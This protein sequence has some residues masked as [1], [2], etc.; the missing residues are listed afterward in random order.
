[1]KEMKVS[2][3]LKTMTVLAAGIVLISCQKDKKETELSLSSRA[4][5]FMADGGQQNVTVSTNES[6]TVSGGAAWVSVTP[7]SGSG[8]GS[9][10]VSAQANDTFD[11]RSAEL[12]VAAGD[13]TQTVKVS[14]LSQSPSID[15]QPTSL[16][17]GYEAGN[18]T[19]TITSNAP[20]TLTLSEGCDWITPDKTEGTGSATV[21]L[22][23][24]ANVLREAREAVVTIKETVGGTA[25]EVAVSQEMGPRSRLTDSLAL[26]EIYKAADGAHWKDGRVWDLD[27]AMDDADEKWY[28]VTLDAETGRVTALKLLKGTILSEWSLPAV[29]SELDELT[30]LRFVDCAVK[31]ALPEEIYDLPKLQVL[32]LTNNQVTGSLSSKISQWTELKQLYI[33]QNPDLTGTLPKEI[34]TLTKLENLNIS[35]TGISGAIPSELSGCVSMKNFMAYKTGLSGEVPDIWDKLPVLGVIQLY[36]NPGLTGPIPAS[37]GNCGSIT[38]IWLYECNLTGNIPASFA[39]LPAKAKQLRIQDNKLSGV[40]P[41]AVKAHANWTTWNAAKYIF[42][43]QEGYGLE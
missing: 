20:W 33:D 39:N 4:V 9:F 34:G 32:Y 25:K 17:V 26:V 29:I 30:D 36:S 31:G 14:Q 24:Q 21:T 35:Q 2:T 7:T 16:E 12:T 8:D 38:S 41:D 1:M 22:A 15:V 19:V 40:V 28:G 6:W 27:V 37:I 3:F 18:Q 42:P 43:Q 5:S 10:T 23:I 11:A 13:K